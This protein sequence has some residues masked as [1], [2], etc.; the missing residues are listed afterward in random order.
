MT[1]G[2]NLQQLDDKSRFVFD[3]LCIVPESLAEK[4]FYVSLK[5]LLSL[6]RCLLIHG[7]YLPFLNG[8]QKSRMENGRHHSPSGKG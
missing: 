5:L 6:I 8:S 1:L 2:R 4:A 3:S 7:N